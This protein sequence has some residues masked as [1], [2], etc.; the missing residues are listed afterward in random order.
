M[1]LVDYASSSDDDGANHDDKTHSP[2]PSDAK[3]ASKSE[4]AA[5]QASAAGR[6]RTRSPESSADAACARS[7]PPPLPERFHDLYA[8]ARRKAGQDDPA[9][10]GGRTRAVAHRKGNWPSHVYL[11]CMPLR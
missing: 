11:E 6:K 3:Q 5:G 1:P 7:K 9:L 8:T 4:Y 10:H 2:S